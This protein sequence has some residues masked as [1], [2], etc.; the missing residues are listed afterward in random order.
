MAVLVKMKSKI[1]RARKIFGKN[2]DI[3]NTKLV[4]KFVDQLD[5]TVAGARTYAHNVRKEAAT[6]VRKRAA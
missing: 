4:Q 6:P 3:A 2:P 1:E 5:M